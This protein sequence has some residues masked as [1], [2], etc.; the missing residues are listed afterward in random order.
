MCVHCLPSAKICQPRSSGLAQVA[1]PFRAVYLHLFD[2]PLLF[3]CL[4]V[5]WRVLLQLSL[6]EWMSCEKRS[7]EIVLIAS[8]LPLVVSL[9]LLPSHWSV[10]ICKFATMCSIHK[11]PW[12]FWAHYWGQQQQQRQGATKTAQIGGQSRQATQVAIKRKCFGEEWTTSRYPVCFRN[13][14]V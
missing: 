7:L 12:G 4:F 9:C 1:S 5:L 13:N 2:S 10:L 8:L 11:M 14:T 3:A 6:M